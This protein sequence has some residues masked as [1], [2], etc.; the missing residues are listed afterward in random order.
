MDDFPIEQEIQ[1]RIETFGRQLFNLGIDKDFTYPISIIGRECDGYAPT[2]EFGNYYG[3]IYLESKF[4]LYKK[5][6][7]KDTCC[8]K[9]KR[10]RVSSHK[11]LDSAVEEMYSRLVHKKMKESIARKK[12][13]SM[14]LTLS[15]MIDKTYDSEDDNIL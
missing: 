7:I 13:I 14:A 2:V 8:T 4:H 9:W 11:L 12:E 15:D 5:K 6:S 10:T 3:I 1:S